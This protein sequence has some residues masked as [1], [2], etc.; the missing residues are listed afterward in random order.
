VAT[1]LVARRETELH[2]LAQSLGA[3]P[4]AGRTLVYA[5]DVTNYGEAPALF[6]RIAKD[7]GGV[8]LVIY[9]AGVM[10]AIGTDEYNI[11]KDAAIVAVNVTGAMAWLNQAAA[12]FAQQRSGTI[13]GIS[14]VA[15][16]RGRRGQPA[17]CASKSAL[18]T[19]LESLRNRLAV[20]GVSVVTI[21][22]GP[23]RTPMTADLGK[24]P[25]EIDVETAA[26]EILAAAQQGVNTAYVPAKW[27]PIMTVVRAIPSGVFRYLKV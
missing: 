5:H 19:Y 6:E 16:D 17:Y 4:G 9:A 3:E 11:E 15:G 12:R 20:R 8:D 2:A 27:R 21:K 26:T 25:L 7:L 1:A 10:P 18:N 24:M 23:V 13:V 14:S 22:P